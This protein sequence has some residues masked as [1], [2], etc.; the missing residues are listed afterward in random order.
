[1]HHRARL[2]MAVPLVAL[3]AL[4]SCARSGSSS[5]SDGGDDT[6]GG[7]TSTQVTAD[8]G[9]TKVACGPNTTG[10]KLG[11]SDQG[12][13]ASEIHL[14][15]ISDVGFT[16]RPGLNQEL[17]DA[18][19]V[20]S[21]WCNDLGGIN[22][23]KVV[24]DKRDAA[25]TNYKP[26]IS[27]SCTTDFALVG[28]G[29]VF[30]DTGQDERLKCLL[31]N[32]P[33]YVVSAE[34]RDSDLTIQP[35]PNR[36]RLQN[37]GAV[38]WIKNKFPEAAQKVAV[39]TGSVGS[40]Q[41]VSNQFVEELGKEDMSVVSSQSYN[42]LGEATWAPFAQSIKQKGARGVLFVGE[43]ENLA[44]LTQ[45]MK[46]IDYTPDFVLLTANFYD[47]QLIKLASG[48]LENI[49][50]I[51]FNP[52]FDS[53]VPAMKK[54]L[55]LFDQYLPKGKSHAVLGL[56]SFA[57]WILFAQAASECGA[58]LTRKCAYENATKITNFDAGG[59]QAPTNPGEGKPS[60]CFTL[61]TVTG[62]KF[63]QVDMGTGSDIWNCSDDNLMTL[64]GDYGKGT[65]LASVGKSLADLP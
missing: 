30:D 32:F 26:A 3:L 35:V 34:A 9:T 28:G 23:R 63:T 11:A 43:P 2:A 33:G 20:F 15:T 60:K 38:T 48:S 29:G 17:F 1:M 8:F 5:E 37:A 7:H 19:E 16:A 57:S 55:A 58:N 31:P 18:S 61:A 24:V 45:A 65:T 6:G 13:T 42:P 54:Y 53:D 51:L 10:E 59:L 50:V 47:Q 40:L 25:L 52:T 44:K 41:L 22:G 56:N 62:D 64:D 12:V 49:Y 4:A 21:K 27:A 39:V 46:A 14:G 36:T